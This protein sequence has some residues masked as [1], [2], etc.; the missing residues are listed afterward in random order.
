MKEEYE[1]L[2]NEVLGWQS[3]RFTLL[4][5]C[6]TTVTG[7]IGL[8]I[9]QTIVKELWYLIIFTLELFISFFVL[10]SWYAGIANS[11]ISSYIRVF[12]E[13]ENNILGWGE[14][15]SSLKGKGN[16][17]LNLNLFLSGI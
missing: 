10:L 2:R 9:F 16:D 7:F 11:K 12:H 1:N 13:R 3:K 14:R 17:R 8:S 4:A 5:I 6:I 15:L